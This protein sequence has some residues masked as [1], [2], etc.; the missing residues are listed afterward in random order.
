MCC[1][2]L[3]MRAGWYSSVSLS[4]CAHSEVRHQHPTG[5]R[6]LQLNV[7]VSIYFTEVRFF[8]PISWPLQQLLHRLVNK[9]ENVSG[10]EGHRPSCVYF[11]KAKIKQSL[12]HLCLTQLS[13]ALQ[14]TPKLYSF[15]TSGHEVGIPL[16][17]V[18]S[19]TCK[20]M[21]SIP[22]FLT[23]YCLKHHRQ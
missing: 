22:V 20:Q 14:Y 11:I 18:L 1:S 23:G 13:Y 16:A 5:S 19:Q 12:K 6:T 21:A 15:Y 4:P 8:S 17:L 9:R 10:K 3:R 2:I 7:N